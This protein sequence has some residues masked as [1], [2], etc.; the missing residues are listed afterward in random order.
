MHWQDYTNLMVRTLINDLDET[1]YKYTDSRIDSTIA[2]AAQLVILELDFKNTYVVDVIQET[3]EPDPADDNQFINLLVYRAAI[4]IVGGEVKIEASNAIAIK[5]GPSAI[6]LRGVS[7]TLLAL[8]RDLSNK[9]DSIVQDYGYSTNIGSAIL[10]P[11]SP[12][13]DY[14]VRTFND[15]DFRGNYFRN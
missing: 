5:D 2:V 10:G 6:D 7:S 3:I 15:Y 8:Y 1:N 12:G 9:Y 13:S 11:Y 4:I 14:I